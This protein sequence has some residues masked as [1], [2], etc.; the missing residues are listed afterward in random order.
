MKEIYQLNGNVSNPILNNFYFQNKIW[1]P[2][3]TTPFITKHNYSASLNLKMKNVKLWGN[4]N[5]YFFF[6]F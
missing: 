4:I 2:T 1:P 6:M 5:K 3:V